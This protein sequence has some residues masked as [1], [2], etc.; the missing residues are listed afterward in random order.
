MSHGYRVA[1]DGQLESTDEFNETT[2]LEVIDST[3]AATSVVLIEDNSTPAPTTVRGTST[4]VEVVQPTTF[5]SWFSVIRSTSPLAEASSSRPQ[6]T[7]TTRSRT[8]R[9]QNNRRTTQRDYNPVRPFCENRSC[10]RPYK[11]AYPGG[12]FRKD[13]PPSPPSSYVPAASTVHRDPIVNTAP[14]TPLNINLSIYLH[15]DLSPGLSN[16]QIAVS[17][18]PGSSSSVVVA[19]KPT[20]TTTA[21]PYKPLVQEPE[22]DYYDDD[23][24]LKPY[25][26]ENDLAANGGIE[27]F[28]PLHQK[29]PN[30]EADI[31]LKL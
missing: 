11:P 26:E 6:R 25:L 17:P 4:D 12:P 8:T 21:K 28:K 18:S 7:R 2:T 15:P 29:R 24:A 31:D 10:R 22:P 9:V 13:P 20:T 30:E 27:S 16:H 1:V 14:S 3:T 19:L 5:S 23:S